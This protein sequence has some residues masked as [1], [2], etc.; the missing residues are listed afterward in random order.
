MKYDINVFFKNYDV[1][2]IS[3]HT[4]P[5]HPFIYPSSELLR[6]LIVMAPPFL[7]I[8]TENFA[9]VSFSTK[10]IID[11]TP[12]KIAN[13]FRLLLLESILWIWFSQTFLWACISC[14]DVQLSSS[15]QDQIRRFHWCCA[16]DKLF[17]YFN[18]STD[19]TARSLK[20]AILALRRELT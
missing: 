2:L 16:L 15:P 11:T 17:R 8:T 12:T 1:L 3:F 10:S 6:D 4:I 19:A 18:I 13:S 5:I 7:T 20:R 14:V 9:L